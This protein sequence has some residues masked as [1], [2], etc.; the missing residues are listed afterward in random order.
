MK[1]KVEVDPGLLKLVKRQITE[2]AIIA[3]QLKSK[4]AWMTRKKEIDEML[5]ALIPVETPPVRQ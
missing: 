5:D 4:P 2:A 3:P 1:K